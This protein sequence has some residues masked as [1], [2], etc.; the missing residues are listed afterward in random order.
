MRNAISIDV[1]DYFQVLAFQHVAP[2]SSWGQFEPRVERNVEVLLDELADARTSATFFV[3]GWV[4][5][6]FPLLIKRMAREG[7]EVASHG[8]NHQPITG[9]SRSDFRADALTARNLLQD[10]SAQEVVGYRAPSYSINETNIWALDVLEEVGYQY[11]SSIY[12]GRHDIYGMPDA[13]RFAFR[14]GNGSLLEIPVTTVEIASS[15]VS[16]GGGGFFRFWPYALFRAGIRRVNRKD[17]EPAVFYLHPW[18]VDPQQPRFNNAPLK[19]RFRHY[20]N[21]SK[22]LPRFRRLLRDFTWDRIDRVF[23]IR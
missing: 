8:Y 21:L 1:E 10:I 7:H 22:T 6:R 2:M 18:E 16:C 15:R 20:L 17:G 23:G 5:E 11:S 4:A 9:L 12:P 3:L 19:S 14:C 13:P